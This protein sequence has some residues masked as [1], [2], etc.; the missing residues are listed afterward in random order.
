[1]SIMVENNVYIIEFKMET[2]DDIAQ[3]MGK[4]YYEKYQN[5]GKNTYLVGINFDSEKRN[6]STFECAALTDLQITC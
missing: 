1:M 3:I 2:G 6:I 5:Q 4:K